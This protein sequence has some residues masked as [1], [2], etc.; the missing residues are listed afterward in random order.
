MS[1]RFV[2]VVASRTALL[3]QRQRTAAAV[4]QSASA[5]HVRLF[6]SKSEEKPGLF[7]RMKNAFTDRQERKAEEQFAEQLQKMA[8]CERWTIKDYQE[9]LSRIT[10]SWRTKIPGLGDEKQIKS[11]KQINEIS[12]AVIEVV[13]ANATASEL[14]EMSR[15]DKLKVSVASGA[16]VEDI[17]IMLQQFQSIEVMH[18]VVR[19]RKLEG[20]PIPHDQASMRSI[21]QAEGLQAMNKTQRKNMKELQMKKGLRGMGRKR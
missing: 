20:K 1:L 11:A 16:S 7:D 3:Q 8:N 15:I 10:D 13:G 12:K 6:S 9:D 4:T 21:L 17:N 2:A 5:H 18:Q 14:L 19:R